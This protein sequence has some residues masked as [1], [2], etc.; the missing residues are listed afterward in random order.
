MADPSTSIFT[1]IADYI[2]YLSYRLT[3]SEPTS[4]QVTVPAA[5]GPTE[6]SAAKKP[7][8]RCK[9][10][11]HGDCVVDGCDCWCHELRER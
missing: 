3:D 2:D 8:D 4:T 5:P 1:H 11:E 7:K 10:G 9:V 6:K